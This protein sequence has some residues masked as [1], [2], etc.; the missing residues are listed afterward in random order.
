M[1]VDRFALIAV[2]G[3]RVLMARF[4]AK[5]VIVGRGVLVGA[6]SQRVDGSLVG[7]NSQRV[8]GWPVGA[9]SQRVDSS[10]VG[11]TSQRF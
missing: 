2:I 6:K 4:R 11:A 5:G 8:C 3:R 1:L 7:A 10:L 9:N